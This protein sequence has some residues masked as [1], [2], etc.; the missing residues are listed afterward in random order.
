MRVT[1]NVCAILG[2]ALASASSGALAD[3][4][5]SSQTRKLDTSSKAVAS[6]VVNDDAET[7]SS[8]GFGGYNDS[9]DSFSL[10]VFT[11]STFP[12]VTVVSV[13]SGSASQNSV[14]SSSQIK[15]SGE[16]GVSLTLT[17]GPLVGSGNAAGSSLFDV[18]FFI[19]QDST[20]SFSGLLDTQAIVTGGAPIPLLDNNLYLEEQGGPILFQSLTDDEAFS[21]TG[22]FQGGKTYR[23]YAL[24]NVT[25]ASGN[26]ANLDR[27]VTGLAS[28]EF[29]LRVREIPDAPLI[30][31]A[32]TVV[33][34]LGLGTLCGLT[35][36]LRRR[37]S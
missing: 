27:T 37:R 23:L 22:V 21:L 30:P 16:A 20:F 9:S 36:V 3:I 28:F 7:K 24:A 13:A 6:T 12:P 14:L 2:A 10:A 33:S 17:R 5:P 18:S 1:P 11:T 35:W 31:E 29:D 15:A 25:G 4:I 32:S 8:P 34:A 26:A 19:D